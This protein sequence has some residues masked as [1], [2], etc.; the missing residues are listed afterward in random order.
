MNFKNNYALGAPLAQ[1]CPQPMRAILHVRANFD[2][3]LT[4]KEGKRD[5]QAYAPES[6]ISIIGLDIVAA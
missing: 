6:V 1:D 4:S 2:E 5:Q 3:R